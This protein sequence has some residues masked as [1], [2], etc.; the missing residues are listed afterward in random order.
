MHGPGTIRYGTS[1]SLDVKTGKLNEHYP[2]AWGMHRVMYRKYS[3]GC[4]I[5]SSTIFLQISLIPY[6]APSR[7]ST[8][9]A[10][11]GHLRTSVAK[12]TQRNAEHHPLSVYEALFSSYRATE[13]LVSGHQLFAEE[14]RNRLHHC[15]A[16]KQLRSEVRIN[17]IIKKAYKALRKRRFIQLSTE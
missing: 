15:D 2:V 3:R 11:A 7:H 16:V 9:V 1:R 10:Q 5:S 13:H 6:Q 12:G 17:S 4:R 8:S 14:I